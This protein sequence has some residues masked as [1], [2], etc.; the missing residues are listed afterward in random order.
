MLDGKSYAGIRRV[1]LRGDILLSP[2]RLGE[3]ERLSR[4]AHTNRWTRGDKIAVISVLLAAAGIL[5]VVFYPE[6]RTFLGRKEPV[7]ESPR[8]PFSPRNPRTRLVV[9]W[10]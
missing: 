8:P 5:V 1:R 10:T 6:V 4:R 9:R 3:Q 2:I 7:S